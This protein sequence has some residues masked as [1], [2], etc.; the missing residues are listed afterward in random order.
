MR[1][2]TEATK[3]RTT[4]FLISSAIV[5]FAC[6]AGLP[7]ANSNSFL[8]VSLL[9]ARQ[10]AGS[11]PKSSVASGKQSKPN[12]QGENVANTKKEHAFR[13]RVEKVDPQTHMLT[14]DGENVP[15]WMAAMT[16][17]YRMD[18]PGSVIVKPGDRITATVY[19][20]DFTTLHNVR[21][22]ATGSA[23]AVIKTNDLPPISYVCSSPGE[24]SVLEDKPGKCPISGKPM[25][26]LR[27]VTVYSCLK[28]QSF[29]QENPGVC[30]VDKS[31]LVPITTA[32]Y[33]TCK[34]DSG[35]RSLQ[36]GTCSDGS[37]RVK[38]YERRPHG[39]HNPRH[40]GQFFMADD[41]WHH[42]EG[43]WVKPNILR[44]YFYNDM[45]QPLAITGFS[46]NA[47]KSDGNGNEI[48]APVPLRQGQTNDHNVLELAV[49]GTTLPA[50]FALRVKFKPSDKERVFDFTFADY[51]KEPGPAAVANGAQAS[52]TAAF[53]AGS[54]SASNQPSQPAA[55]GQ[56]SEAYVPSTIKQEA[57]L[58]TTIPELLA[59][60]GKRAQSVKTALDQGDLTGLWY[61][62]IGAKDVALALEENHSNEVPE[63]KRTQLDS[64]VRRLTMAAWQIDA[65]G[66]LGNKEKVLPLYQDF[67]AA[68]AD[69]ESVYEA[70]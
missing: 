70:R 65:A 69:V 50:N 32:L 61:P 51:S 56:Q 11:S 41:S 18:N 31:E 10:S 48:G 63:A 35:A 30:P 57:P 52:T 42:L 54:S 12:A 7:P 47:V 59:E 62:A 6:L 24:E 23:T 44:V 53:P 67:A 4:A 26:P 46:A 66:D 1:R 60:L 17:N 3:R 43:T 38:T 16:M 29:I 49:P 36:P 39:D 2:V 13:G 22:V 20:G 40:G 37:A 68:V 19:D 25:T 15:G 58:P 8:R 27:L 28:F 55:S 21:V 64:A 9:E 33:F 34:G 5:G 14:I 45:T